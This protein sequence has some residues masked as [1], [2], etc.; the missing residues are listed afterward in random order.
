M[1]IG[2]NRQAVIENIRK[3]AEEGDFHRKV[4]LNDPVLTKEETDSI[5]KRYLEK[6]DTSLFRFKSFLARKTANIFTWYLNRDTEIVGLEGIDM[7][8]SYIITSNHFSQLENTVL[9]HLV[10]KCG[11]KRLNI[12][13]Q[14]TNFAM[15]GFIGFLLNYADIIPLSDDPHY[16]QREL[17]SLLSVLFKKNEA[18]LIYP[19]QEM[20]F[21]YRKPRP[22]KGGAYYYAAKL[23]IPVV[24]CFVE[25]VDLPKKDTEEFWKTKYVLHVLDVLYPDPSKGLHENNVDLTKKDY[26]LKV[27]AYEKAYHKPLHYCFEKDDIAGWRGTAGGDRPQ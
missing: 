14:A 22:P 15:P 7:P 8:E 18:V 26:D 13:S 16:T 20:W 10:K 25:I 19:E 17:P 5:I 23:N 6:H 9:R 21:N 4:E 27:A 3:A 2:G 12:I 11:K 1:I 24:S